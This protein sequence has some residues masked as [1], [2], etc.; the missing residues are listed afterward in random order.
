MWPIEEKRGGKMF[1]FAKT[2]TGRARETNQD[3]I[4]ISEKNKNINLY[5]LADRYGRI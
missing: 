5:I 4:Y 3:Y 1:T 2:D